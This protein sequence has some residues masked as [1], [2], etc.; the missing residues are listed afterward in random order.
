M[1]SEGQLKKKMKIRLM[2]IVDLDAWVTFA[3]S[4]SEFYQQFLG[5]GGGRSQMG[6]IKDKWKRSRWKQHVQHGQT[7]LRR[8]RVKMSRK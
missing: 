4:V 1:E 3:R 5:N 7:D 2:S 6:G 8:H